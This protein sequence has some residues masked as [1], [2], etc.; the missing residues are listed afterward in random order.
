MRQSS[1]WISPVIE[2][3]RL[4]FEVILGAEKPRVPASTKKPRTMSSS[5]FAH[6]S[7][8]SAIGLLVI[9]ILAP[10]RL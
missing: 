8:T 6:T 3:R 7:A 5:S 9:H 1:R 10:L 4:I 2:A